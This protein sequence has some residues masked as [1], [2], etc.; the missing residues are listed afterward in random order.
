VLVL[1][2]DYLSGFRIM[3]M[4]VLVGMGM[5]HVPVTMFVFVNILGI[6]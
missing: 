4:I 6:L 2:R 5:D 1:V 3:L